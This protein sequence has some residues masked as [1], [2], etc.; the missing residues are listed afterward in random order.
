MK[1]LKTAIFLFTACLLLAACSS[2]PAEP[3]TAEPTQLPPATETPLPTGTP[4]PTA[5]PTLAPG[6]TRTRETD[7]A[8]MVYIPAGEF[9]MGTDASNNEAWCYDPY[10]MSF[11]LSCNQS[12][13]HTVSLDA[14]WIDQTEVT[15]AQYAQCLLDGACSVTET[16]RVHC[17]QF[18]Y[19]DVPITPEEQANFLEPGFQTTRFAYARGGAVINDPTIYVKKEFADYPVIDVTWED[20]QKYC[21]WAGGRLPTEAEWEKAARGTDGKDYPWGDAE[22]VKGDAVLFQP[23]DR[24]TAVGSHPKDASPY[25]V[26]DMAGNVAEWVADFYADDYYSESPSSNPMGPE[27][28]MKRVLRGGSWMSAPEMGR[29]TTRGGNNPAAYDLLYGFRCVQ[30]VTP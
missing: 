17:G 10:I 27:E 29:T 8:T 24:T 25:G 30:D 26:F 7:G 6:D 3:A 18:K 4:L 16:Q 22:F 19:C 14:F 21:Q 23:V 11:T 20:A 12:P 2:A 13:S 5:T 15:F 28:G 1:H 9:I